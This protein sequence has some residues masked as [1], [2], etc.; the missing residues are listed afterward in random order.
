[1]AGMSTPAIGLAV[2]LYFGMGALTKPLMGWLY[3]R[4]GARSALFIPL[5]L[6]GVLGLAM[7]LA[8]WEPALIALAALSGLVSF[9]S[10]IILTATADFCDEDVLASS[11]GV[12]YA[13][14]GL[15]FIAPLIG[16]W[17]AGRYGLGSSYVFFGL[18]VW[19]GVAVSTRLPRGRK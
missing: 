12:I 10:P 5:A 11:V 13:C 7:P 19:A 6:T 2:S 3:D 18:A 8:P 9:V 1:M 17:L 15:A 14:D 4:F 16:G